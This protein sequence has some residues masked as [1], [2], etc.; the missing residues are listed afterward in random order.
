MLM[1]HMYCLEI[2]RY[3]DSSS[4]SRDDNHW[5]HF[6]TIDNF[7]FFRNPSGV[8]LFTILASFA[9]AYLSP[10]LLSSYE[11]ISLAGILKQPR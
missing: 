8:S 9:Y 3:S 1:K 5:F 6:I 11:N 2:E 7:R 10:I 4:G